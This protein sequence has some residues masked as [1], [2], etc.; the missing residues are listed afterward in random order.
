MKESTTRIGPSGRIVI[1]A[2]YRKALGLSVGDEIVLRIEDD[3]LRLLGRV[4]AVRRAQQ[5]VRRYVEPERRLVD[6]LIA[7]RHREADRE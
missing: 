1:P 7:A 6:E 2:E 4:Q 5:L 3:E